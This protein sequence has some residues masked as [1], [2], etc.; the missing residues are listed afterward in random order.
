MDKKITLDEE[1]TNLNKN[2]KD[3]ERIIFDYIYNELYP[4]NK[5]N[6][7]TTIVNEDG[8]D[9]FVSLEYFNAKI[10]LLFQEIEYLSKKITEIKGFYKSILIF[11]RD[12]KDDLEEIKF[13]NKKLNKLFGVLDNYKELGEQTNVDNINTNNI[14]NENEIEEIKNKTKNI[15]KN[16]KKNKKNKKNSSNIV[17]IDNENSLN[18]IKKDELDEEFKNIDL[19]KINFEFEDNNNNDVDKI[20]IDDK[21]NNNSSNNNSILSDNLS[22]NNKSQ[23]SI[24]HIERKKTEQRTNFM[25][26]LK[27]KKEI[28]E[29]FKNLKGY[30]E[31]DVYKVIECTENNKTS[32][33]YVY[34]HLSKK[35]RIDIADLGSAELVN[36]KF[37]NFNINNFITIVN[38]KLIFNAFS[39]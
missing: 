11:L 31:M 25:L 7:I 17:E 36:M 10:Y 38:G 21:N 37:K 15:S 18:N 35:K 16:L 5:K 13:L 32:K 28:Y 39:N 3:E 2:N 24:K 29:I 22:E 30:C 4:K 26:L 14:I 19:N 1:I 8:K 27:E 9:H 20:I 23:I 6:N 34:I 12:Y 33:F